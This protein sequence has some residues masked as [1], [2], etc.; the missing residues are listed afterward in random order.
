MLTLSSNGFETV[1]RERLSPWLGTGQRL[2]VVACGMV[3]A[4]QGWIEAP[5]LPTPGR[6]I[7]MA[8][9]RR[10][11]VSRDDL[12]VTILPGM[13]QA[14]PADVMRGEETQVAG[15]LAAEPHFDGLIC[16]P[17]T[18]TKW[19]R[20]RNGRVERFRTCMTGEF[21]A[22]L[23]GHSVLRHALEGAGWD[24]QAFADAA[25][26]AARHCGAVIDGLFGIRASSLLTGT[27]AAQSRARLSGLLIGAE[28]GTM[29]D[30]WQDRPIVVIGSGRLTPLYA[31]VLA[32]QGAAVATVDAEA[33]TL[34]CLAAVHAQLRTEAT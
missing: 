31:R 26:E 25:R 3:G 20:C 13:A 8:R 11:P 19:V 30:E 22:L 17:G 9:L 1:L 16:L 10:A 12:D 28:I 32:D 4:R 24:D 29:R 23:A 7:E 21:Y 2:A 33:A 5:Y 18:H 34:R 27:S 14:E 15:H 6:P